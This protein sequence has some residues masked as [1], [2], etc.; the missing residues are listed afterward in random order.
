MAETPGTPEWWRDR[1][2]TA[3]RK[4][5]PTIKTW[6]NWYSGDHPAPAGNEK[7]KELLV[8]LLDTVGLNILGKVTD[9]GHERMQVSTFKVKGEPNTDI[10][11]IWNGNRFAARSRTLFQEMMALSAAYVLVDPNPNKAGVPT[12]T[13]EHPEQAITEEVH[14]PGESERRVGLKS[15]IDDTQGDPIRYAYLIDDDEVNV[16][17]APSRG[18]GWALR[19]GWEFQE[20]LSGDNELEECSLVPFEN[21]ARLLRDPRPE[22]WPALP[23]QRR[24]NKTLMDRMAMQDEAAIKAMWATGLQIP[25]DPDTGQPVEPFKRALDRMFINENPEGRFGQLEAED[26]QQMLAAV[27]DDVLWAAVLVATPP[28]QLLR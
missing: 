13:V 2:Y 1:L 25:T 5:Q 11:E 6:D 22:W 16:W 17:A 15:F 3:L 23:T 21:R 9:A 28:D 12:M 20:S 4:R 8:R 7:A 27:K 14:T 19:P 10:M 24:I 26:I 18:T